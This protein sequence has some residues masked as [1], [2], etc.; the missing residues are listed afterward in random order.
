MND[1]DPKSVADKA[2]AAHKVVEH[3]AAAPAVAPATTPSV[4]PQKPV[5][6]VAPVKTEAAAMPAKTAPIADQKKTIPVAEPKKTA[7]ARVASKP[8]KTKT[9]RNKPA[10]VPAKPI[11][12][13]PIMTDTMTKTAETMKNTTKDV[14]NRANAMM[15]DVNARTKSAVE[16]STKM[17]EE[18]NDFNKGNIEALVESSKVAAKAAEQLGQQAAETARKNFETASQAMK[19]FASVKT[20]TEFFQL[21]SEYARNA[22]DSMMSET[23]RNSETML[24]LV[25]EV[26]QPISNRFAVAAEKMK[27]AA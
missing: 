7:P 17:M 4:A 14:Q 3:K 15:N 2:Q 22:F 5:T 20:P 18:M 13:G 10:R 27:I 8:V 9:I 21:Q 26:F 16:R 6:A 1:K 25:G 19:S 23:S 12:K 11:Q 24:K